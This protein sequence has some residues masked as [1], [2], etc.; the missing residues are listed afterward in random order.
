L[1]NSPWKI[2]SLE[3]R[4]VEEILAIQS[5]C[6]KIAQWSA[7]DYERVARQEM[8]GW[9]IEE[10]ERLAGF[11]VARRLSEDLEILNLAVRPENRRR[12]AGA[13]LLKTAFAWSEKFHAQK[14]FL[15]VRESNLAAIRFY[16]RHGFEVSG[17]RPKYYVAPIEDA[18]LLTASPVGHPAQ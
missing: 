18:L 17:R 6:P 16:Q 3:P 5:H 12:G 1:K 13:A 11:I 2:R 10:E 8:A 9:V 14:I 7:W 4:D 15:E